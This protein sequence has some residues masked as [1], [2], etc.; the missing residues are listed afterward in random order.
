M[1]R[2]TPITTNSLSR[3]PSII[4]THPNL[5]QIECAKNLKIGVSTLSR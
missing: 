5:T 3:M 2:K 1:S 4:D